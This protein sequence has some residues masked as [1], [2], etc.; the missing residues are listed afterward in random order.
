[1]LRPKPKKTKTMPGKAMADKSPMKKEIL[2]LMED[3]DRQQEEENQ[4][5]KRQ[6]ETKSKADAARNFHSIPGRVKGALTK[7]ED[8]IDLCEAN[9]D[10]WEHLNKLLVDAGL[11]TA[12]ETVTREE[13]DPDDQSGHYR[14]DVEWKILNFRKLKEEQ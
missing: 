5:Y 6:L 9:S 13:D 12:V 4:K 1:M 8:S 7:G 10:Y 14:V 2:Q 3:Y 11:S